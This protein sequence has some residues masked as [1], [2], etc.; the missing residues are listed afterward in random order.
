MLHDVSL[1]AIQVSKEELESKE[2]IACREMILL[3]RNSNIYIGKTDASHETL[4][5]M[6]NTSIFFMSS[7]L[8]FTFVPT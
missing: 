6:M 3:H 1:H 8:R 7:I 5:K 2:V 4:K